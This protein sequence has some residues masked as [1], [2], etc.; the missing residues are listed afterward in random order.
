MKYKNGRL[1]AE[2]VPAFGVPQPKENSTEIAIRAEN[3]SSVE[4]EMGPED[5]HCNFGTGT[6]IL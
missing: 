2:I 3:F 5:R 6:L 4:D 1:N